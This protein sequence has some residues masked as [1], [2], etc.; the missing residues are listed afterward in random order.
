VTAR[1]LDCTAAEYHRDPCERPSLSSS[2]AKLL[3][4]ESPAHA[5]CAHPRFGGKSH[6]STLEMDNGTIIHA[7]VLGKGIE[8]VERIPFEN[9]R[10]K[11]AQTA[12]DA[13]RDAGKTPVC[14]P[15]FARLERTAQKIRDELFALG[16]P[17]E[18]QSEMC[19][20]W[21]EPVYG[22]N[23]TVLCRAQLDHVILDRMLALDLKTGDS[24][25]PAAFAK[26]AFSMG[27]DI[28]RAAYT[29]ALRHLRP[30]LAGREDF[31]FLACELEEP[32]CVTPMRMTGTF[33]ELGERRWQRAVRIWHEC[34]KSQSWPGYAV[35]R[36]P[37]MIEPP[38]WA[39]AT[40]AA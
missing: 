25:N 26:K 28:Q 1:I 40:E 36:E 37:I 10:K 16:F 12:R 21:D 8:R 29:S 30:S 38:A 39:L 17:L 19:L 33:R 27:Y 24:A 22:T 35:T 4:E 32:H 15:H 6:D 5:W 2:I 20:S 3:I 11:D 14:E 9:Y 13:A 31:V 18:G 23:E 34:T 7:L